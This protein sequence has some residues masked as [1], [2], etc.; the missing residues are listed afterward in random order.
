MGI[1][2]GDTIYNAGGGSE[3]MKY[4]GA[5]VDADF[6]KI[7]NGMV[8]D[9]HNIDRADV[10]FYMELKD[11]EIPDIVINVEND[12][13]ATIHVYTVN[14]GLFYPVGN[15]GGNTVSAGE[16]YAVTIFGSSYTVEQVNNSTSDPEF[17]AVKVANV[18]APLI[19]VAD[20]DGKHW[21]STGVISGEEYWKWDRQ[22]S[23]VN[24]N[25]SCRYMWSDF[26]NYLT[27]RGMGKSAL[28]ISEFPG[29]KYWNNGPYGKGQECYF[30]GNTSWAYRCDV[31]N[32]KIWD[33]GGG[34][35][36]GYSCVLLVHI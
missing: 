29:Y 33:A 2:K 17:M 9:Y 36:V 16:Q 11:N 13:A 8:Y 5:L 23:I 32:D 31:G 14:E 7:D 22:S 28:G 15:V 24:G 18:I 6:I 26:R 35:G 21:M 4:G 20:Y 19:N 10:N 27:D 1:F 3:G 34:T 30:F 25:P 12:T